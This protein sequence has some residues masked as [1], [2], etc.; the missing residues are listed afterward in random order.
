MGQ[1]P[2]G[3]VKEVSH[4]SVYHSIRWIGCLA[5]ISLRSPVFRKIGVRRFIQGLWM[6]VSTTTTNSSGSIIRKREPVL[7]ARCR[8]DPDEKVRRIWDDEIKRVLKP[9]T[10]KG[11]L[12]ELYQEMRRMLGGFSFAL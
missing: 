8:V 9:A 10:R 11:A 3:L 1:Y 12:T 6:H 7:P 2:F 4:E 5:R